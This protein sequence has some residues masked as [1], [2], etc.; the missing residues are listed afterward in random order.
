MIVL[1]LMSTM[2]VMPMLTMGIMVVV[3]VSF[4]SLAVQRRI[5]FVVHS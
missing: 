5:A 1:M 3:A 2:M 4:F